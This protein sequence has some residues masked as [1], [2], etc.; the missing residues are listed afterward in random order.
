MGDLHYKCTHILHF[1]S[2]S[3]KQKTEVTLTQQHQLQ[4][5]TFQKCSDVIVNNL[6]V[7]AILPHLYSKDLITLHDLQKLLNSALTTMEKAQ[8]LLD[9]LPRKDRFY[10]KFQDCLHQTKD[11]TGHSDILEALSES[12]NQE[13]EKA[14]S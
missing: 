6:D 7:V 5:V 3:L 9:A 11:G 14:D 2:S 13:V 4:T 10:E 12:Y 8:F 1:C